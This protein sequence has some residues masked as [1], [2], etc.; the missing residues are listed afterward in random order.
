[1]K[2]KRPE[3]MV[4]EI[5]ECVKLAKEYNSVKEKYHPSII[6]MGE[7]LAKSVYIENIDSNV[8]RAIIDNVSRNFASLYNLGDVFMAEF[9]NYIKD[10]PMIYSKKNA[11]ASMLRKYIGSMRVKSIVLSEL[12]E[13]QDINEE[14]S[15]FNSNYDVFVTTRLNGDIA[16]IEIIYCGAHKYKEYNNWNIRGALG[17]DKEL[18]SI[19][20][21]GEDEADEANVVVATCLNPDGIKTFS[22]SEKVMLLNRLSGNI[23]VH[24]DAHKK[25]IL[26]RVPANTYI[27]VEEI[28]SEEDDTLDNGKLIEL[29]IKF[30]PK[31]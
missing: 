24:I 31:D 3:M 18:P 10:N 21:I 14:F 19:L 22:E 28:Y 16:R 9:L 20:C 11:E 30:F 5:L 26:A 25:F 6:K 12:H 2:V 29:E 23:P 15:T 4:S 8:E 17:V 13:S 27:D 1:M 7:I